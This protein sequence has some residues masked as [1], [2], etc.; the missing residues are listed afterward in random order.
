MPC[1]QAELDIALLDSCKV[2]WL[3]APQEVLGENGRVT[4]LVCSIMELGA[5]DA[6]GRRSPVDTGKTITL[7][8]DMVIKATGQMPFTELVKRQGLANLSGK[9]Q[10]DTSGVTNIMGVFAGG[11]CVNGGK[12]VVDAV[13]AGKD[14]AAGILRFLA[15]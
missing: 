14:G 5:P 9:I 7:E 6:S 1:T 8:A 12:E 13:Q 15:G 3:A 11:D 2:I 4:G 10:T